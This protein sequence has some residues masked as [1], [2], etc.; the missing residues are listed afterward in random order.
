MFEDL[1]PHEKARRLWAEEWEQVIQLSADKVE[2]CFCVLTPEWEQHFK[3][4]AA[5]ESASYAALE[6][7][8]DT[9]A[10]RMRII[11]KTLAEGPRLLNARFQALMSEPPQ[12]VFPFRGSL[13]FLPDSGK[14]ILV[15]ANGDP[16]LETLRTATGDEH[17]EAA[18][19]KERRRQMDM[20]PQ[21]ETGLESTSGAEALSSPVRED[22]NA[23]EADSD[24]IPF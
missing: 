17:A 9:L 16:I 19:I 4:E 2:E 11:K 1:G 22:K 12:G 18:R 8:L 24:E 10:A 6:L 5:K 3:S 13:Q 20:F 14:V 15:A 21:A 23:A 7:E